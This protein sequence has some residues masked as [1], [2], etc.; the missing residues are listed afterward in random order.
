MIDFAGVE[1]L[2]GFWRAGSV[3]TMCSGCSI[4]WTVSTRAR[5]VGERI[6]SIEQ[7]PQEQR[8]HRV[9]RD[10]VHS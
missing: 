7:A 9:Q 3:S 6:A 8:L 4:A 1:L 10:E 5:D 2:G